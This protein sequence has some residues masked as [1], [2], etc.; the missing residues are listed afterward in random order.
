MEITPKM[1]VHN[2]GSADNH[3]SHNHGSFRDPCGFLFYRHNTLYRQ[4]NNIYKD[5]YEQL[6]ASGLYQQLVDKGLL[7]PHEEVDV[8]FMVPEN[9]F[10]VIQPELIPFISYPYEWS[11]S[12]LKDAALTT[13]AIQEMAFEK[14]M[15]LKDASAYNIQFSKGKAIFI[16]TLSFEAYKEG[17]PWVA[18]RQF[19]QHFLAPLALMSL[20]D[21]RLGQLLKVHIDGIPLDLAASLLPFSARFNMSTYM[22][23]ILHGKSQK[24]HESSTTKPIQNKH[25]NNKPKVSKLGFQGIINSLKKAVQKLHWQPEGTEWD[26]YYNDTNYSNESMIHKEEI[27]S[28]YL[29]QT[30]PKTVWDLGANDGRFSRLASQQKIHTVAFD[31]DPSAVEKNYLNV[32]KHNEQNM[33]PL[34]IDLT[35]PSAAIGWKNRERDSFIQRGPVDT[36]LA[37]ALIHH[38]AISNNVPLIKIADFFST[39]SKHL[40]I[41]FVPK[42]DSQVQRLLATREDVFPNYTQEEFKKEFSHYF[43]IQASTPVKNSKR[44]LFLLK[45]KS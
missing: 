2:T 15:S 19:C 26:D 44:T 24:R 31:V 14:G 21:I 45:R 36:V 11:F 42:E 39:L 28:Q 27:V 43:D 10:K 29:S 17:E 9:G 33:L 5:N 6:N 30:A 8:E 32:I 7:V 1:T 40:V 37:L 12:Q 4:V 38:L 34:M 16:D 3:Q 25:N 41:E 22:H 20:K 23:I 18:Y 13:L 35:N